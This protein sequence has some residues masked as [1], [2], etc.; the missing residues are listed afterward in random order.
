MAPHSTG[1]KPTNKQ[2]NYNWS[3]Y[4]GLGSQL[5]VGLLLTIYI[6]K[7]LDLYYNKHS[8]FAWVDPSLFILTVLI[9][10]VKDTQNKN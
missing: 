7:K 2:P 9:S 10:I 1:N 4:V 6:G 3:K 5:I 8:F